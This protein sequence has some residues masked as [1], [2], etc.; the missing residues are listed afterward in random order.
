[1]TL[2]AAV[3]AAFQ[4]SAPAHAAV[5]SAAPAA[6]A[7]CLGSGA[8]IIDRGGG[9]RAAVSTSGVLEFVAA[10]QPDGFCFGGVA[11]TDFIGPHPLR[12]LRFVICV[13]PRRVRWR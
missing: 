11:D 5:D 13:R 4:I 6:S 12:Q 7:V 8:V 10:D 3:A 1:M 2:L 9:Y